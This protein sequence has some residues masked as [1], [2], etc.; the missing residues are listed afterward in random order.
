MRA[1]Q[2]A[3]TTHQSVTRSYCEQ[4][5]VLERKHSKKRMNFGNATTANLFQAYSS[6]LCQS[7]RTSAPL[8]PQ[9]WQINRGSRSDN[10]TSSVHRSLLIAME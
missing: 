8:F 9:G 6:L 2:L 1:P 10:L 5:I 4:L 3:V 7:G